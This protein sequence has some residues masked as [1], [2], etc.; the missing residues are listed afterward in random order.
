PLFG[1]ARAYPETTGY[2]LD[3]LLDYAEIKKDP[4][5]RQDAS[6]CADWLCSIQLPSG[7]WPGLLAGHTQPSVFNTAQ[8]LFGLTRMLQ[9][10]G[11]EKFRMAISQATDWLLS[12]LEADGSWRQ[13]AYVPGFVPSYYTRAV[14]GVLRANQFLKNPE[15]EVAMRKALPYYAGRFLPNGAIRDWGFWPGKPA[16]THTIAYTVEGFLESALL[17]AD[18]EILQKT[19]SSADIFYSI[20]REK[21]RTAGRYDEAW[22]GDYSFLCLTGN[23]Q[24]SAIFQRLF[25]LTGKEKYR[26]AVLFFLAE[27]VNYQSLGLRK[28]PYGA[29]PGSSPF[30]GPY[31]RFR[32]PNWGVKF[33]LDAML[34]IKS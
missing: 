7:A 17:L 11:E 16:F 10:T 8:I 34:G 3:T 29:L 9:E 23:A 5:L 19:M 33:F 30:W 14:W 24:W 20:V 32:Y 31:L 28:N 12:V 13:A 1:W 27:I 22:R 25:V 6:S 15:I 26:Q 2:L 18:M 21:G 4:G